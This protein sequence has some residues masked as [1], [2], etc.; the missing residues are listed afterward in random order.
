MSVPSYI[1]LIALLAMVVFYAIESRSTHSAL[2]FSIAATVVAISEFFLDRWPFA[3]AA[4]G[5]AG[6]ALR[7]WY[8]ARTRSSRT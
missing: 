2:G 7:R 1:A 5:F 8:L 6:V 3:I 4:L